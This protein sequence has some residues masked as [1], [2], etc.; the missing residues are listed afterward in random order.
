MTLVDELKA[1]LPGWT[2]IGSD[3]HAIA[4]SERVNVS[5]EVD[6]YGPTSLVAKMLRASVPV[7]SAAHDTVPDVVAALRSNLHRNLVVMA[8][9]MTHTQAALNALGG[10]K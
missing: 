10:G 9:T 6:V 8:E 4:A 5:I 2:V 1:A 3:V 7:A